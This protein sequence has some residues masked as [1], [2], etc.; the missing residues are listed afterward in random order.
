[1]NGLF[2]TVKRNAKRFS[3]GF[4]F[5]LTKKDELTDL[6]FQ[7]VISQNKTPRLLERAGGDAS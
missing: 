5:Q 4:M 1:M 6:G 3:N 2:C 7:F